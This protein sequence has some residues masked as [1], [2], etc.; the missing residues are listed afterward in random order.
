MMTTIETYV[1][2][3]R[4]SMRKL[5]LDPRIRLGGKISACLFGGF[6]LSAASLAHTA[7]PLA[8]G[9]VCALTGWRAAVA[10]VGAGLGYILF[11]GDGGRQGLIWT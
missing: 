6:F 7:L 11:W 10:A 5:A 9:L 8:M 3:G 4:N 2:S 1:R